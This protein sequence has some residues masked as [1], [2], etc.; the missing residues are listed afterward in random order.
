MT[1]PRPQS[2]L[3]RESLKD[4]YKLDFLGLAAEAQER[5]VEGALVRHVTEFLLELGAAYEAAAPWADR[6]PAL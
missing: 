3:A 6:W 1:L 5:A 4:P 2:D